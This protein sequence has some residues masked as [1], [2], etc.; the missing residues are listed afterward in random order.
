M[1]YRLW[2]AAEEATIDGRPAR[3]SRVAFGFAGL[4]VPPGRHALRLRPDTRWVKIGAM[5]S[6]FTALVLGAALLV[7]RPPTAGNA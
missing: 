7:A 2:E 5:I 4:A 3:V 1:L 6:A